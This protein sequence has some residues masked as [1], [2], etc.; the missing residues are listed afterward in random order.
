MDNPTNTQ[1]DLPVT[2]PA[3]DDTDTVTL[4]RTKDDALAA[5]PADASKST[6]PWLVTK[7]G[8]EVGWVLGIGYADA[9]AKVARKEGYS[10]SSGNKAAPV[11]KESAAALLATLDPKTLAALGFKKTK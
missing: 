9:L 2:Q 3:T 1:P 6:K 5:K 4:H 10:V 7:N 8:A 11:T